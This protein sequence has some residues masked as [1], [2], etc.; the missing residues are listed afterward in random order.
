[1]FSK[2]LPNSRNSLPDKCLSLTVQHNNSVIGAH[3]H[4]KT[5]IYTTKRCPYV[6]FTSA[7]YYT[8]DTYTGRK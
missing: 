1:M 3:T 7:P 8:V 2:V 4:T 6:V 5:P